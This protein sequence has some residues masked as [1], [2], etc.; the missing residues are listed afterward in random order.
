MEKK[1]TIIESVAVS[2][3]VIWL[4]WISYEVVTLKSDR[5]L[6]NLALAT[7]QSL[8]NIN[9]KLD[10]EIERSNIRDDLQENM[11]KA[12]WRRINNGGT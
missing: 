5:G 9:G 4:S 6:D 8:G 3:F 11:I 2:V 1:R 12:Q 10:I 7:S